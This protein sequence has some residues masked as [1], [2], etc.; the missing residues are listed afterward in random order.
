MR[1]GWGFSTPD[2]VH[3]PPAVRTPS[4]GQATGESGWTR[5][6]GWDFSLLTDLNRGGISSPVPGVGPLTLTHTWSN[7][8]NVGVSN[9]PPPPLRAPL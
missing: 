7:W 2:V 9:Q 5:G 8:P 4:L 3:R 6:R 1:G